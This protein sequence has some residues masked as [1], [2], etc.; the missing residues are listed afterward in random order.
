MNF[1]NE[2]IL[3][4]LAFSYIL[5]TIVYPEY[6]EYND[7]KKNCVAEMLDA[8]QC[9]KCS[10]QAC[11]KQNIQIECPAHTPPLNKNKKKNKKKVKWAQPVV[12]S[13]AAIPSVQLKKQDEQNLYIPMYKSMHDTQFNEMHKSLYNSNYNGMRYRQPIQKQCSVGYEQ[14]NLDGTNSLDEV[15]NCSI[16][17]PT[18]K[19]TRQPLRDYPLNSIEQYNQRPVNN[20]AQ[21]YKPASTGLERAL[22]GSFFKYSRLG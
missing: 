18:S 7:N 4:L 10:L 19:P 11:D 6:S 17:S 15:F 21:D 14:I 13:E 22:D 16:L 12:S 9:V 5:Y 2:Q 20:F 1:S 8:T 3:I